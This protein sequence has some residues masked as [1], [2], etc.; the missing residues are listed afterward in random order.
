MHTEIVKQIDGLP[1]A[2][3]IEI[4]EEISRGVQRD[5]RLAGNGDTKTN[6]ESSRE[7]IIAK[8]KQAVDGLR[9]IASVPGKEPPTDEEW[10]E[11]RTNYLLEK[12]K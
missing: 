5:L 9:G 2:E 10:R 12:Y 6:R 8:R 4:I 1:I 11:E 7:K 3:R